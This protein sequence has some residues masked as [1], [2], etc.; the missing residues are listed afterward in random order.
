MNTVRA[1]LV[2]VGIGL[3]WWLC[4]EA[5][6]G[7]TPQVTEVS[8][9]ITVPGPRAIVGMSVIPRTPLLPWG[10]RYGPTKIELLRVKMPPSTGYKS[11]WMWTGHGVDDRKQDGTGRLELRYAPGLVAFTV[12]VDN[13]RL[14][15]GSVAVPGGLVW[16]RVRLHCG[17]QQPAL[18]ALIKQTS[19]KERLSGTT[20][21][22]WRN[23]A[24][25]QGWELCSPGYSA[26]VDNLGLR[27]AR[28]KDTMAIRKT[29]TTP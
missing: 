7:Q 22:R 27:P 26:R 3:F 2:V 18:S 17:G 4:C 6:F 12:Y 23:Q 11:G 25:L 24:Q 15:G 29:F 9:T 5:A 20:T 14:G 1:G 10:F 8:C 13:L 28:D 19:I 21:T 16:D